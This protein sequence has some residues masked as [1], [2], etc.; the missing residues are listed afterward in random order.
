[1]KS[2]DT[3]T[4]H[5]WPAPFDIAVD[6]T[7][8]QALVVLELLDDLR[9]RIWARYGLEIQQAIRDQRLS[10]PAEQQCSLPF[11]DPPF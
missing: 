5:P 2:F 7:P 11:D 8:E 6:W 4:N 9:E 10:S 3:S 1:M